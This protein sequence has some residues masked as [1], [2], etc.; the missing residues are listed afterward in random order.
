ML[1]S[2]AEFFAGNSDAIDLQ[3]YPEI[4]QMVSPLIDQGVLRLEVDGR[5]RV[6]SDLTEAETIKLKLL[7]NS[8]LEKVFYPEIIYKD[9]KRNTDWASEYVVQ[10]AFYYLGASYRAQFEFDKA[11]LE[12]VYKI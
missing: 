8:I 7:H 2:D 4:K 6:K 12:A 10:T 5:Y 11:S 1:A 9:F 3:K